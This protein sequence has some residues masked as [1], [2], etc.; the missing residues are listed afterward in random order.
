MDWQRLLPAWARRTATRAGALPPPAVPAALWQSTVALYPFLSRFTPAEDA[1]L[2]LLVAHFL[3]RKEFSGAHGLEVSDAMAVAIAAQA[4]VL[5]L[6]WG[7]PAHALRW[8]E[9][10]VGIVV[11]PDDVIARRKVVD[12]AGVVHHYNEELMGE[13]MEG[14]PIMLSWTAVQ[15]GHAL[16]GAHSNV[17]IHEFAHKLDLR[18]GSAN[19]CP[20]LPAGFMGQHS[21]SA[22]RQAWSAIWSPA[23]QQFREQVI[24]HERFGQP[25]PWLDAYG[26]TDP[27][28]FFAVACEAYWLDRERMGQELPSLV[29]ALDAFFQRPPEH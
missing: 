13:A 28:E 25:A 22:A 6:Y 21:A 11:Q 15:P 24:C 3:Q 4:C 7:E 1:Q 23:Y 20:P 10:F 2:Q 8:Y 17:V 27:A 5:L 12:D 26:A 9:D 16:L 19:G 29:H 14:G 18:D